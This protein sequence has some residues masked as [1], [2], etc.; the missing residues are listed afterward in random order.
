MSTDI[1]V[2]QDDLSELR[3]RLNLLVSGNASDAIE[4]FIEIER[5]LS[6]LKDSDRLVDKLA[7]LR[8]LISGNTSKIS[9]LS[10]FGVA[11]FDGVANSWSIGNRFYM[12]V[13]AGKTIEVVPAGDLYNTVEETDDNG[14]PISFHPR[15]DKY[16]I[17]SEGIYVGGKHRVTNRSVLTCVCSFSDFK[18]INGEGLRGTGDLSLAEKGELS[19]LPFHAW[20][21]SPQELMQSLEIGEVGWCAGE[22]MFLQKYQGENGAAYLYNPLGPYNIATGETFKARG[23]L[24]YM[25]RGESTLYRFNVNALALGE[26]K[27]ETVEGTLPRVSFDLILPFGD[28]PYEYFEGADDQADCYWIG[29][30]MAKKNHCTVILHVCDSEGL[31]LIPEQPVTFFSDVDGEYADFP[32]AQVLTSV[33][34]ETYSCIITLVDFNPNDFSYGNLSFEFNRVTDHATADDIASIAAEVL[35]YGDRLRNL[36]Y[37]EEDIERAFT[38]EPLMTEERIG[39]REGLASI[40]YT[41]KEIEDCMEDVPELTHADIAHARGIMERW[42]A[43]ARDVVINSTNWWAHDPKLVVFPKLDF[44]NVKS[45]YNAWAYCPNLAFMPDMDTSACESFRYLYFNGNDFAKLPQNR[46]KRVPNW[47]MTNATAVQDV[48]PV[49]LSEMILPP[50]IRVPKAKFLT[51]FRYI[52]NTTLPEVELDESLVISYSCMYEGSGI[53]KPILTRFG[54]NVIDV[55]AIYKRCLNL[56]DMRGYSIVARNATT[57][58]MFMSSSN[59]THLLDSIVLAETD[60]PYGF[61]NMRFLEEVPDYSN[62]LVKDFYAGFGCGS[63]DINVKTNVNSSLKRIRGLNFEK[64]TETNFCFGCEDE[65]ENMVTRPVTYVRVLNVGKGPATTLDFRCLGNWGSDDEGYRSLVESLVTGSYDRKANGM[66]T[67]VIRLPQSVADRLGQENI[68]LITAKGYTVSTT[69]V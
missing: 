14:V 61:Y 47:D 52:Y 29:L 17:S 62:L 3:E 18:T 68:A 33:N 24:L 5:F 48:Y 54:D 38:A 60:M 66:P 36:G 45:L 64:V 58:Q 21:K 69:T 13:S 46:M 34:G 22:C 1:S 7:E 59:V 15:D 28:G 57:S 27:L 11:W 25:K 35:F 37:T 20:G 31:V 43:T 39:L 23:D 51:L 55:Q 41:P 10:R 42:D 30:G 49:N 4:S 8:S 2:T 6:G 63:G 50:V 40:G 9:D 67:A 16:F 12:I 44:S 32:H 65:R 19:V 26:Y 53:S 56:T